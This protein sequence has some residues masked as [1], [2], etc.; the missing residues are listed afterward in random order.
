M[1]SGAERHDLLASARRMDANWRW[2]NVHEAVL[3]RLGKY[4]Q[5]VWDRAS[6][7]AAMYRQV[8]RGVSQ[9]AWPLALGR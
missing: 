1:S 3:R 9:R 2:Q 8:R 4:D 7:D 5:V 6:I